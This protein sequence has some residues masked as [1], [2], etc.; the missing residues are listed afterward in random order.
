MEVRPPHPNVL[1]TLLEEYPLPPYLS[2]L[3]LYPGPVSLLDASILERRDHRL[4]LG[5][6]HWAK[7]I[8]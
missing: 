5:R 7:V 8:Q 1:L 3:C 6:V 4:N 2:L